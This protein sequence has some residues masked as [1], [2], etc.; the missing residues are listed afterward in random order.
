MPRG[1]LQARLRHAAPDRRRAGRTPPQAEQWCDRFESNNR[2]WLKSTIAVWQDKHEDVELTY[3]DVDT[4]L[5]PPR[6]RLY[7]LVGAEVIEQVWK[8]R[9]AARKSAERSAT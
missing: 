3:E 5:I 4:S 8:E 2:R 1:P 6:P 7:G 9:A